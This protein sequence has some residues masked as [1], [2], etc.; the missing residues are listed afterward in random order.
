MASLPAGLSHESYN[1]F[2][3]NALHQRGVSPAGN[4]HHDM[5]VL[6]QFWSHF[7]VR[8]FNTRMYGEFHSLALDD[9]SRRNS[10]LGLKNLVQYYDAAIN[11]QK[12]V[13]DV[14]AKDYVALVQTENAETGQLGFPKLRSAWRNGALNMKNRKKIATYLSE[15]LKAKLER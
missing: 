5:E 13:S 6:Y 12:V 14:I 11:G 4:C 7:L 1:T 15:E 3:E 10:N 2:R 9:Q 8:N